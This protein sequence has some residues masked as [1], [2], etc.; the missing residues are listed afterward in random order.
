M[1]D[2]MFDMWMALIWKNVDTVFGMQLNE[3]LMNK[4]CVVLL[5]YADEVGWPFTKYLYTFVA[6]FDHPLLYIYICL[7]LNH[8][9][10]HCKYITMKA[11]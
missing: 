2:I 3:Y 1:Y 10:A 7:Y 8:V 4:I 6:P 11:V 5:W 9:G